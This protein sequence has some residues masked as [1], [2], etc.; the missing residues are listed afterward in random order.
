MLFLGGGGGRLTAN[1]EMGWYRL[2]GDPRVSSSCWRRASRLGEI[3]REVPDT[4]WK[5]EGGSSQ[6]MVIGVVQLIAKT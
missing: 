6:D 2:V 1:P 5:G 3:R 4:T